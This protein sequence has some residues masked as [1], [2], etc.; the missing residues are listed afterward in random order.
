MLREAVDELRSHFVWAV[1]NDKLRSVTQTPAESS[2]RAVLRQLQLDDDQA[3]AIAA[4]L[5]ETVQDLAGDVAETVRDE[6]RQETAQLRDDLDQFSIDAQWTARKI[7]EKPAEEIESLRETL[8]GEISDM[9]GSLEQFMCDVRDALMQNRE[10][11]PNQ[12]PLC[13]ER[14]QLVIE[15]HDPEEIAAEQELRPEEAEWI[16]RKAFTGSAAVAHF[17]QSQREERPPDPEA[18]AESS[19]PNPPSASAEQK[20]LWSS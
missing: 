4:S 13:C 8:Q 17:A 2:Q 5:K 20:L 12:P 16:S 14:P 9:R 7:R 18:T 15:A 3:Q 6:L 19:P 1:R 10:P 11:S